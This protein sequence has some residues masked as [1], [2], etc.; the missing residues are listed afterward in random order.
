MVILRSQKEI[1]D[2]LMIL[3]L[4]MAF[5]VDYSRAQRCEG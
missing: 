2:L 1:T 3:A 5:K 4:G